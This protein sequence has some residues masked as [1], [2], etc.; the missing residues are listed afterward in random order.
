MPETTET[1]LSSLPVAVI[2]SGPVGLA[3]A[4]HLIERGLTPVIFEAGAAPSAAVAAWGHVRLFSP[5]Q[6]DVDAAA[7]RLLTAVGWQEPDAEVLPTGTELVEQYL[8]PLAAVPAIRSAL[9]TNSKVLAVS[10]EGM[11]KTRSGGRETTPFLIRVQDA[12]GAVADHR[13]RAVIDASGTW[14]TPNPLGQA[15]LAA[16]GETEASAA[17]LITVPLPDVTGRDRAR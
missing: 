10:R 14:Q 15:G 16:P 17:G 3:S 11:D 1:E 9:H 8:R 13:V 2:G 12:S 6:Y 5:W 7:R 4:A